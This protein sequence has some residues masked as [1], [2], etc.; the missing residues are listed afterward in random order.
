LSQPAT[1]LQ[2]S[3]PAPGLQ[4]SK[5]HPHNRPGSGPLPSQ[6]PRPSPAIT[7]RQHHQP[8]PPAALPAITAHRRPSPPQPPPLAAPPRPSPL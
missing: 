2:D 7:A 3:A 6:L 4:P 1:D 8:P 5:N